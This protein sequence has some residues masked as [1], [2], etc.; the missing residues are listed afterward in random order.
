MQ[1]NYII[2]NERPEDYRTVEELTRIAFWNLYVPG[3]AEHYLVHIMRD[4]HDFIRALDLVIEVN[5]HVIGN[6]MYTKS[7][8]TDEVG[9]EKEILTFGPLSIHPEHQRNGYG[10]LLL[11]VSFKKAVELGYDTIIIMGSPSNYVGSGFQSCKRY[12]V[13]LENEVY[14]TAMLVKE[15]IPGALMDKKWTYRDSDLF[16]FD[17]HEAEV[18]DQQFEKLQKEYRTSQEE[19]YI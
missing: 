7:W 18:F 4:H 9:N 17:S 19:F 15:L 12:H 8:L 3:C 2:R 16:K 14:P 5:H 13:S 11:E 1:Q 6:V 10:K